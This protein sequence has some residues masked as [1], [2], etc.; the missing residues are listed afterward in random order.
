VQAIANNILNRIP[1]HRRVKKNWKPRED[2]LL[3]I[4]QYVSAVEDV[5]LH[6]GDWLILGRTNYRIKNMVPQLRERGIY[7]EL[8][9][10]KSY[11]TRLYKSIQNYTRWTN[12]DLLSISECKDVLEFL[13]V[14]T[15]NKRRTYV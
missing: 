3:P 14:D 6:L 13:E 5:P 9:N 2:V 15:R 1:D 10:R 7:F 8:K 11:K 12:G 4:V